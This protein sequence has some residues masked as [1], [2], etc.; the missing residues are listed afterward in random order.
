MP[1]TRL[2]PQIR[3][4]NNVIIRSADFASEFA[5]PTRHHRAP[6]RLI[7]AVSATATGAQTVSAVPLSDASADQSSRPATADVHGMA[8]STSGASPGPSS[9]IAIEPLARALAEGRYATL[10]RQAQGV[11]MTAGGL[12][13]ATL[14]RHAALLLASAEREDAAGGLSA[15][16]YLAQAI[17]HAR[18]STRRAA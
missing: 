8:R 14:M 11:L 10:A 4:A 7:N 13:D 2:M 6:P 3:R 16:V 5:L 9:S 15:L 18:T 12:G 1:H 17:D